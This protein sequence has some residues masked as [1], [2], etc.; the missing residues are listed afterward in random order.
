M[1]DIQHS[2]AHQFIAALPHAQALGLVLEQIGDG[3]ATILMPYDPR[4]IG[5]PATGGSESAPTSAGSRGDR[6][7][8]MS[9]I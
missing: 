4:L 5:D 2:F 8:M 7:A 9:S 3:R 6:P 1:A